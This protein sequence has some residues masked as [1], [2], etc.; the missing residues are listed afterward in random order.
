MCKCCL[1]RR[2]AY[3]GRRV[4]MPVPRPAQPASAL[5]VRA[6]AA[7]AATGRGCRYGMAGARA[8]KWPG[9]AGR[10]RPQEAAKSGRDRHI[11]HLAVLFR[12]SK[13]CSTAGFHSARGGAPSGALGGAADDPVNP[14][15]ATGRPGRHCSSPRVQESPKSGRWALILHVWLQGSLYTFQTL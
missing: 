14:V 11:T 13:R 15:A 10:L 12:C 2:P 5:A 6:G 7:R 4:P 1:I 8:A 3:G 9:G